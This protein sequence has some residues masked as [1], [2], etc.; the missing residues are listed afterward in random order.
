[1]LVR[2]LNPSECAA[3]FQAWGS[4]AAI[5]AATAGI[6]WQVRSH[7]AAERTR[8]TERVQV[9]ASALFQCRCQLLLVIDGASKGRLQ[10]ANIN[11]ARRYFRSFDA[12][13][14]VEMPTPFAQLSFAAVQAESDLLEDAVRLYQQA[15]QYRDRLIFCAQAAE[16]LVGRLDSAERAFESFLRS[17]GS[18]SPGQGFNLNGVNYH[19][20][21]RGDAAKEAKGAKGP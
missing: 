7:A 10:M 11:A 18:M 14:L 21:G 9:I 3:W 1:M 2:G 20:A 8:Q 6:W 13:Q 17:R 4:I 16:A 15:P 12:V 19:P 5:C